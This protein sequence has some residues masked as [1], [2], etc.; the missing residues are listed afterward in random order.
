[1]PVR[2]ILLFALVS[3]LL[4]T[5]EH[6]QPPNCCEP[7][8]EKLSRSTVKALV[9]ETM[10]IHVPCCADMLHI[11]GTIVLA[12]SVDAQGHVVCI[13]TV[14]GHPLVIGVAM[15]SVR[16]WKFEPYIFKGA[17]KAFCGQLTLRFRANEH[18]VKYRIV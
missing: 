10:P 14:S 13:Q 16:Q 7:E 18:G 15:D 5:N 11:S 2:L 8:S 6:K 4:S 3:A 17:T 12:I 9:K 1:M